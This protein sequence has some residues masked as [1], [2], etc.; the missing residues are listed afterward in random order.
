MVPE[1]EKTHVATS[2]K[3]FKVRRKQTKTET[4]Q[5][6]YKFSCFDDYCNFIEYLSKN[7]LTMTSNIAKEISVYTYKNEYYLILT[8]I[9][10]ENSNIVKFCNSIIEFA[11]FIHHTDLFVS[12][13]Y[14]CGNIV[15]KNNAIE[16]SLKHFKV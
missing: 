1:S 10:K 13:L 2:K 6:I 8:N 11:N 7:N 14:E 12:K 9:Y 15:I 5:M 3:K 4:K 16:T